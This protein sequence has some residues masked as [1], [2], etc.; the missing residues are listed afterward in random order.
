MQVKKII[1]LLMIFLLSITILGCNQDSGVQILPEKESSEVSL[2]NPMGPSVLSISGIKG[3]Y[4]KGD[5]D[6]TINYW[7]NIEEA[8]A[9][10]AGSDS[11]F[12]VL[13]V[14]AAANIHAR[15]IELVMLGVHEWKAFYLVANDN[16]PFSDW[17][18]LE[19]KNIYIAV[20]RGTTADVL[21]RY[22]LSN[23]GINPDQDV[24][25]LYAPPQEIV[26]LYK[27]GKVDY[28]ALPE[29]FATMCIIEDQGSIVVDLQ[30]YWAQISGGEARIPIAGLF[31]K[32]DFFEQYPEESAKVAQSLAASTDWAKANIDS[33]LNI[34]K[35]VLPIPPSIMKV[36]IERI[37][38]YY[39][40]AQEC[41]TE[42]NLFLETMHNLYPEGLLQVPDERFY[43]Q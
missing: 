39:I 2:I 43:A 8:I 27:A 25:L 23:I 42:V 31:V 22:A 9:L 33:A 38:S 32:K 24:N 26:Q 15:G 21:I 6:I 37:E 30:E 18:S 16:L 13:P 4:I 14:T 10:L 7:K 36:A 28:A 12:A 3:G 19:G 34:S 40:P 20:G 5:I 41:Q 11:S 35:E 29:P 1:V 17:K